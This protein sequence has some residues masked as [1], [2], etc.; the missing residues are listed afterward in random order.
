MDQTD[1]RILAILQQDSSQAVARVAEQVNL[2]ETPCWRRIQKLIREGVIQRQVALVSAKAIGLDL[3]VFVT[4]QTN[5]HSPD[6]LANF[7]RVVADMPEIMEVHRLAGD[8]DYILKIAVA[9]MAAFDAFYRKLIAQVPLRN[10]S[11]HLA[12]E[13]VKRTTALPIDTGR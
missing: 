6:W 11:S 12:M 4:I 7:T 10:V 13:T 1:R 5:D 3:I 9:D 8:L 2:S